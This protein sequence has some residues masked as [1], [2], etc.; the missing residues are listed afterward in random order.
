M[1]H[2]WLTSPGFFNKILTE[3]NGPKIWDRKTHNKSRGK[4]LRKLQLQLPQILK[5]F[6]NFQKKK[7]DFKK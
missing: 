1:P 6:L 3:K 4:F 5:N 7:R 2:A